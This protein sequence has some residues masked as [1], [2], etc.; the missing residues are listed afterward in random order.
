[1]KEWHACG[2]I[3]RQDCVAA[4]RVRV[5]EEFLQVASKGGL[6]AFNYKDANA[7][8]MEFVDDPLPLRGIKLSGKVDR[9]GVPRAVGAVKIAAAR[10][11]QVCDERG[12]LPECGSHSPTQVVN[13]GTLVVVEA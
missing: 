2:R 5:V 6:T 3:R 8:G 9:M 4:A 11:F 12:A 10:Y 7:T 1:M 13:R